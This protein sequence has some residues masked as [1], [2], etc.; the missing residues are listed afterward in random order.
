MTLTSK[1]LLAWKVTDIHPLRLDHR[2]ADD[3]DAEA[4]RPAVEQGASRSHA[5]DDGG[6]EISDVLVDH[7]P[8]VHHR[9]VSRLRQG[10]Q[11]SDFMKFFRLLKCFYYYGFR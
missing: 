1:P 5:R 10:R 7:A 8:Q 6:A 4:R 9:G 3:G 11:R 2:A